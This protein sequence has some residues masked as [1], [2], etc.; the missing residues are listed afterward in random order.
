[1]RVSFRLGVGDGAVHRTFV[2]L[3]INNVH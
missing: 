3:T 2:N 1:L